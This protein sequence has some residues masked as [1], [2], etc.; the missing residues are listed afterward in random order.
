MSMLEDA[1]VRSDS[2]SFDLHVYKDMLMVRRKFYSTNST[3][4]VLCI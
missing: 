4:Q 1:T 2:S 3:Q